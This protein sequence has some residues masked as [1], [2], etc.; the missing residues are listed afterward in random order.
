LNLRPSGYEPDELPDCSTPR[1]RR[2]R[3][4]QKSRGAVNKRLRLGANRMT[5]KAFSSDSVFIIMAIMD[6]RPTESAMLI[7]KPVM[8]KPLHI[9]A[10][11][12]FALTQLCAPLVHA[13]VDGIQSGGAF[14]V[15][16][17]PHNLSPI[18]LS[19]CHVESY[20]SQAISIPH[21]NQKDDAL[22]IPGFCASSTRPLSPVVTNIPV[23]IF[24]PFRSA[25]SAYHKPHTQ[26][27][28]RLS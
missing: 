5:S 26:A 11:F 22:V 9:F 16:D 20:E 27:P 18:G 14:H 6:S 1:L 19:Q 25:A 28:P 10:I 17:I 3:T 12:L 4:L 21:Q 7:S 2:G 13:H 24:D 15:H 23:D 8:K